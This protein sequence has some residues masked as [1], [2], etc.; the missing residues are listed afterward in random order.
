MDIP[1]RL[2]QVSA[3]RRRTRNARPRVNFS[4]PAGTGLGQ[5]RLPPLPEGEDLAFSLGVLL[6]EICCYEEALGFL[7]ISLDSFGDN[8]ATLFN[9]GLCLFHLGDRDG[10][11]AHSEAALAAEPGFAPAAELRARILAPAT[12]EPTGD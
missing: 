3:K 1:V 8:A 9:L 5:E 6:C 7:R 2:R 12:P 10:A 11:L 4:P